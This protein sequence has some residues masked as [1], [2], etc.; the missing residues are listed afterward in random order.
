MFVTFITTLIVSCDGYPE[1]EQEF[2][3]SYPLS[4]EWYVKDYN[5]DSLD[6]NQARS[7]YYRLYIYGTSMEPES[8][9]WIDNTT[10]HQI[11]YEGVYMIKT[12]YNKDDLSFNNEKSPFYSSGAI[13]PDSIIRYVTISESKIFQ[14]EWPTADSIIF[15][16]VT[17]SGEG[18]ELPTDTF[19]S[20]GYRYK[21]T[22]VP[23][24]DNP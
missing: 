13:L 24:W 15:K 3:P 14:N 9:I 1:F 22:E 4:G 19:Y 17:F 11:G 8:K 16:V 2:A 21:G 5:L 20:M 10:T 18:V 6:F 23:T 12:T 7:S